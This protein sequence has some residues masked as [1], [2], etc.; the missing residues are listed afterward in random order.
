M[1]LKF[2]LRIQPCPWYNCL[3]SGARNPTAPNSSS[4]CTKVVL[5]AR[6]NCIKLASKI[7]DGFSG[8]NQNRPAFKKMLADVKRGHINKILTKDLSRLGRN[9]LEVGNLAEVFLP[10]HG[11]ELISLNEKLDDMMVFRN[12]FNE[13]HSKSTGQKVR[14]AKRISA[15]SGKFLGPYAPF[16]YIKDPQNRHKLIVDEKT[17]PIIRRIFQMRLAGLSFRGIAIKLNEDGVPS[18]REYYYSLKGD[19]NP[20]RNR[21][22]WGETTIKDII[23][24]EVYLGNLVACKKGTVSYKNRKLVNKDEKDHVRVENTHEPI[25]SRETWERT[26]KN[27]KS[28]KRRD[29]ECNLFAGVLICAD[30]GFRL[31]GHME[32]KLRKNGSEYKFVSYMCGTY[33]NNG[34]DACTCHIIGEKVLLEILTDY[35][36]KC[37]AHFEFDEARINQRIAERRA[38]GEFSYNGV[39][40]AE[41]ET[42]RK[43]IEK[44][45]FVM[46]NLY[47]DKLAKVIP[48]SLFKR[49]ISK[50]EQERRQCVKLLAALEKRLEETSSRGETQT[51]IHTAKQNIQSF[52]K[53]FIPNKEA[54]LLLVEKIVV[55]EIYV[56]DGK[57]I[58]DIKIIF[59]FE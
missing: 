37:A 53:E 15:Q 45:D 12:W 36:N 25:I 13:Q 4:V 11:C 21:K 56:V 51:A 39:Y 8:T 50:Y 5:C 29:G 46:E 32:R 26:R 27:H 47:A 30:C 23:K 1:C 18:P 42:H 9:Y 2:C 17:A 49:Q 16:G 10:Q 22:I 41:L 19:K 48:A 43:H 7:D 3:R 20:L 33:G 54:L 14:A 55:G 44:L 6:G 40:E 31:R 34:K 38:S 35:I 59:N 52:A 28:K 58:R 57:R 24:N